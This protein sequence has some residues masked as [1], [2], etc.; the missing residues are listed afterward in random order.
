M[1]YFAGKFAVTGN[2]DLL[3]SRLVA[4]EKAQQ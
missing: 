4:L 3:I 2:F 1:R